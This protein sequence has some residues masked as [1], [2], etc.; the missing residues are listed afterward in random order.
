MIEI[1][2][3]LLAN[4]ALVSILVVAWDLVADFT[5]RL[6][7]RMQSLLLGVVMCVG[8][9]ISMATALSVSGFV[10]DLRAAFIAAAA[11]FGG[12]PAMLIATVGSIAYRVH[13]GGQGASAGVMGILITAIVGIAWHHIVAARSRTMYDIF[14]LGVTVALAGLITLLVIPAQAVA[15]LV[16][17]STFPSLVFRF[18]STI[19]I[20]VLLDRQQRRREL[21]MSNMTYRA[22]VRELPDCLNIKDVDGRFIAANPATAEMVGAA[23]VDDLIGKT[24]FDFYP[25]EVAERFRQDEMGALEA[26][27]TLRIDQP[28][29][30]PDG[31]QGWLYTLKAPFRDESGKI[32]GVITYNRDIT[33]QK[34]TAQLKNDF[35]STVSHELRTPLT[36]IRGSLGLIAAGVAGE[37]PPKAANLVNIAHTNSER[38]VLLIND[39]LDMEKIESGVI[40]FKI[41]Q[42]PVRQVL[43]QAIAASSNY[44][45]DSRIRIVLVD[46]APRAEANIDPDRLHQVM[47]NLLSNGIKF[48]QTD[49]TVTVKFQR[50]DRD[51]LRISVVDQGAGIPE[52]FRS[53]IFG[54]FEQADA[55]STRKIGGTG[56]GLSIVKSITEKLGGAVS[57]ETEE[58]QGTSFHVDLPEAHRQADKPVLVER[59]ARKRD[60]RLRV[61]ICEDEPDIAAVIAAL[62]D[63]EGFSSDV[64]PDIDTAKALLSSRD[65]VALTLDIKLAGESGIKLFHDLRASPV[66]SDIAVIVISAVADEARRSLN[67]SAVGII[68]WLEKPVDSKRLHAALAKI[69]GRRV[70]PRPQVLHVE[71]DEGVL[72]VMSEGLGSGVSI[73]SAKTLQEARQAVAKHRFDLIILDIALPDGS[74]LDLLVDLP[75]ETGV[76]VFS[77]AELD[78]KLGD[79]VQAIMTKT[80]AS[81]IDVAKLVRSMLVTSRTRL[82][83]N[84]KE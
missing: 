5:G 74:G 37:L 53:R 48:S 10:V 42:M 20:G 24:D 40:T 73:T 45:A 32:V 47:A 7:K 80:K 9:I 66:N 54:K 78:Q 67:G 61:L 35:I 44:M 82:A 18:L 30:L 25:K 36:S 15:G 59:R 65:Y 1:W 4:L 11:F 58:G 69:V 26:G 34:R 39:I 51:M 43:E 19:I 33:E 17:Q 38:L 81:E 70:E 68:D 52:A 62:L 14:G 60:G 31:R 50:R 13:L 8:A 3:S 56:L 84:A 49:G 29:L 2:Q 71:D 6:S 76:I 72:A 21:L 75:L 55:S 63:A 77:A 64:A 79:R 57:F 41:K 22:M 83:A 28:A 16:Q 27:Q 23:S 46:D 12:W